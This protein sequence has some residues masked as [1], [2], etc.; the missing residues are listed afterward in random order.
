MKYLSTLVTIALVAAGTALLYAKETPKQ[1]KEQPPA[2]PAVTV[3]GEVV[4]LWCFLSAGARG[5][6]HKECAVTCAKAGNPIG[7][8]DEKG[9]AYV[10]MG[11]EN[12]NPDRDMLIKHMAQTVNVKGKLVK[13][14]GLTALYV[15]SIEPVK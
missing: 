14:A 9:N 15:E 6:G 11:K 10:L 12:H 5:Q 7:L 2:Q 13:S 3:K 4:D 8:V 1:G